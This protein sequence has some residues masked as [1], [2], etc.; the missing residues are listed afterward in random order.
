MSAEFVITPSPRATLPVV[1]TTA[2]FPVRRA[3]CIG[4]NYAAHAREMGGDPTR[5]PP[6]FFQK[7]V[8]L[9]TQCERGPWIGLQCPPDVRSGF[10]QTA[11]LLAPDHP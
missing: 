1:G 4:R 3:Y 10:G 9:N 8:G 2:R 11:I 7:N 6:V 5:E